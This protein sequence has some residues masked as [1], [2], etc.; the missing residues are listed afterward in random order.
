[1]KRLLSGVVASCAVLLGLVPQTM[2]HA[3]VGA[4]PTRI[5]EVSTGGGYDIASDG[6]NIWADDGNAFAEIS[7]TTHSIINT[8]PVNE[9][10]ADSIAAWP[11]AGVVWGSS[12]QTTL[13]EIDATNA[14][15]IQT[16]TLPAAIDGLTVD[17]SYVWVLEDNNTLVKIDASTGSIIDTVALGANAVNSFSVSSDGTDV[18]IASA[19]SDYASGSIT[20][21]AT[22][23]DSIV[24]TID[25]SQLDANPGGIYSDGTT[26]W[27]TSPQTNSVLAINAATGQVTNDDA[28]GLNPEQVTGDGTNI[29]VT[30]S[31][32]MTLTELNSATNVIEANV[33]L[34]MGELWGITT[35]GNNVWAVDPENEWVD[36]IAGQPDAPTNVVAVPTA[37]AAVVSWNAPTSDGG[38]PIQFYDV[39][40]SPGGA[41]CQ[42]SSGPLECAVTGLTNGV[43]YTFTVTAYNE[44][45][46]SVA[47]TPSA[48]ITPEGVP[49]PPIGPTAVAGDQQ[50][51]LS[52]Q[53]AHY[54]GGVS[55]V[56]Y[57]VSAS[58]GGA[59][60]QT[61][62]L[63]CTI[64]GLTNLQSYL[65]HVVAANDLWT[66]RAMPVWGV[67][68][69]S[70]PSTVSRPRTFPGEGFLEVDW[71]PPAATG[72]NIFYTATAE[73]GGATCTS[74]GRTCN[75]VGLTN[76][77]TYTVRVVATND[78]GAGA[79]S[80]PSLGRQ[81]FTTPTVVRG[82]AAVPMGGA[83]LVG[84]QTPVHTAP[85]GY[86][87]SFKVTAS[88][89]GA[90]CNTTGSACVV[91]GLS[92]G[93]PYR[94]TVQEWALVPQTNGNWNQVQSPVST[95]SGVVTPY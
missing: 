57:T 89:G 17:S 61:L 24:Q 63:S 40:A 74:T 93:R 58:P 9:G 51:T 81:P 37:T 80:L 18:W 56:T 68:P 87:E 12:R 44:P 82:V 76:W 53:A 91:P 13:Y 36:V 65:F 54:T 43:S 1:M 60:C 55:N 10:L 79:A 59:T 94:F 15:V 8:V 34:G 84:W 22:A 19:G 29:W 11:N 70:T 73:P 50:V 75:I 66:S 32:S 67:I 92:S 69:F 7:P 27:V 30:N 47:S 45:G 39:T 42:W 86:L 64:T 38:A 62:G 28:L 33:H 52:W 90:S 25:I 16:I 83:A 77:K 49:S 48:A 4:S 3:T 2:A 20:E 71:T 85:P 41:T 21:V 95:P 35:L 78:N 26:V 23:D 31:D 6:T 14:S 88:P 46:G 72:P 5:A